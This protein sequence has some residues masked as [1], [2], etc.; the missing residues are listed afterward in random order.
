[1]IRGYEQI[2]L[3]GVRTYLSRIRQLATLL[4]VE[5]H[6]GALTELVP[7]HSPEEASA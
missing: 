3:A 4:T 1:V 5:A 2:K 6:D 7:T